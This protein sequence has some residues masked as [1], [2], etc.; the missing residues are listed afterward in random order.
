MK[1][2]RYNESLIDNDNNTREDF[3][4]EIDDLISE[5]KIRYNNFNNLI[6]SY[7][8]IEKSKTEEWEKVRNE[9]RG[10]FDGFK[11]ELIQKIKKF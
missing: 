2:K 3:N 10:A 7:K 8:I 9:L 11:N 1:I 4:E 6:D 5:L